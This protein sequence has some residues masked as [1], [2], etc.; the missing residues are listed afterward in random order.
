M[1]SICNFVEITETPE[2]KEALQGLVNAAANDASLN[3]IDTS[4]ITDMSNLFQSKQFTGSI[5]CWDVSKV[6][7]MSQM[8]AFAT[9]FNSD[10]SNGIQKTLKIC[11]ICLTL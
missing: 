5:E 1:G 8:F 11:L 3:H 9:V 6:K 10:I 7:N 4:N 2:T